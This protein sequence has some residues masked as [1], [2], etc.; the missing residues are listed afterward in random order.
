[1]RLSISTVMSAAILLSQMGC[2][3]S[4]FESISLPPDQKI[5]PELKINGGTATNDRPEI[6]FILG[7]EGNCNGYVPDAACTGTL[8]APRWVLTA[9][10]C[11]N[12]STGNAACYTFLPGDRNANPPGNVMGG[13]GYNVPAGQ[14]ILNFAPTN[15]DDNCTI[16]FDGQCSNE[17]RVVNETLDYSG[18]DDIA[19]ILLQ[20]AI[21]T[22]VV[23]TPATIDN[24]LPVDGSTVTSYGYG[25][26]LTNDQNQ[27][28]NT[29]QWTFHTSGTAA[30][31]SIIRNP[32]LPP[33]DNLDWSKATDADWIDNSV[34]PKHTSWAQ[35]ASNIGFP[36]QSPYYPSYNLVT[37]WSGTDGALASGDSGGPAIDTNLDANGNGKIWAVNSML[38]IPGPGQDTFGAVAYLHDWICQQQYAQEPHT[39]CVSGGGYDRARAGLHRRP[40]DRHD[41]NPGVRTAG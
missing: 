13:Y 19:L 39:W 30:G 34:P 21:P 3:Q 16:G 25:N 4:P 15:A 18:T 32:N 11:V 22:T 1:M 40:L 7:S 33:G 27:L 12:Y 26:T 24:V 23:P 14:K 31:L 37:K 20:T 8:V 35:L 6:G 9:A 2:E 10:H 41:R 36:A 28:K 29:T 38:G 5:Q 17:F